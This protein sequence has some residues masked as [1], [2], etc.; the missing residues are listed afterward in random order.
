MI[1]GLSRC[2]LVKLT[3]VILVLGL[4]LSDTTI[5]QPANLY[6]RWPL[7]EGEGEMVFD[8]SGNDWH[9]IIQN[10]GHGLGLDGSVWVDDAIRGTVISFNGTAESAFVR[11]G[12]IPQM[13]LANDFTWAFWAKQNAENTASNDIILGNRKDDNAVDFVPRQFI[14]FTPTKFEWHM[15]A[16]GND[17]LDY[18]DIPADV[19]LH[20]AVVKTADQLTYYRN[21]VASSSGTFTQPLD[22]P[23]PLFFGGD[24]EGAAGENWSGLMSDVQLYTRALTADE[25]LQVM[26]LEVGPAIRTRSYREM[27]SNKAIDVSIDTDLSWTA[28]DYADTHDVYFS[29]VFEDVNEADRAN[30]P[31][32]LIS[33]DQ[34]PNMYDLDTLDYGRTYY[35]RIDDVN[36][37]LTSSTVFK[38]K[39]WQFMTELFSY[40]IPGDRIAATASSRSEESGG[41]ENTIDGSGLTSVT[42]PI[43]TRDD[44]HSTII[45]DMW[46]SSETDMTPWIQYNFDKPYKLDSMLVWNFNGTT[47]WHMLGLKAVNVDYSTNGG[48]TWRSLSHVPEFAEATGT[49]GYQANT[50]VPFDN[51]VVNAVK[52]TPAGNWSGGISSRCGLSEIDFLAI[53]T[54]ASAPYPQNG[55]THVAVDATLYWKAGREAAQHRLYLDTDKAAVDQG[56]ATPTILSRVGYK[57]NSQEIAM[58]STYYWRID[59]VNDAEP[60][61]TY[62]GDTWGFEIEDYLV[63]DDFATYLSNVENRTIGCDRI[64]ATGGEGPMLLDDLHLDRRPQE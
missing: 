60:V 23:Q 48:A 62:S 5:A 8:M 13:T 22:V 45:S 37:P 17:N 47:I 9:G 11:A 31:D 34:E 30:L 14:K 39:T 52:L 49:K 63:V 51:L 26:A 4:A 7:D 58:G 15:N 24:N 35:W 29:T 16:N 54:Y 36:A 42:H 1:S 53:P 25:V 6:A 55:A 2:V 64:A 50:V 32:A 38:G 57:L 44:T 59:E 43:D 33:Q 20:H 56:T 40:A 18:D 28:G 12:E 3:C 21:G 61:S 46:I 19:W 27:P 10:A 41:P